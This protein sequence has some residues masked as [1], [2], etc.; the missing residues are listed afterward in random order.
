MCIILN[1]LTH[2]FHQIWRVKP[3]YSRL[4]VIQIWS[5]VIKLL[6]LIPIILILGFASTAGAFLV[7]DVA[8]AKKSKHDSNN[9]DTS[10]S[11]AT[12]SSSSGDGFSDGLRQGKVD[13]ESDAKAGLPSHVSC[14]SEHSTSYCLGYR[15]GY[16]P[17]YDLWNLSHSD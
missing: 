12:S 1:L 10:S 3:I 4:Y 8:L 16:V 2:S 6:A 11:S 13:G 7:P 17:A 15:T 5:I 14:G 9:D